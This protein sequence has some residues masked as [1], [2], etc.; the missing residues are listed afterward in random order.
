MVTVLRQG[1]FR[2]AIYLEDHEPAHVHVY[3]DGEVK[4]NLL[5]QSGGRPKVVDHMKMRVGDVRKAL[6]IVTEQ[7]E[8]LLMKWNEYHGGK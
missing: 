2:I 5:S 4:I 1:G 7:Q 8:M 6:R 3:G